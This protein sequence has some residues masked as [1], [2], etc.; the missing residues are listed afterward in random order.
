MN[1]ALKNFIPMIRRRSIEIMSKFGVALSDSETDLKLKKI[2]KKV[3]PI[4]KKIGKEYIQ[5]K[6]GI[7]L[8]DINAEKEA[9]KEPK[10][11]I[12]TCQGFSFLYFLH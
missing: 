5:K 6:Y 1:R 9:P 11:H 2:F 7:P 10:I 4:A 12:P 8:S 3:L